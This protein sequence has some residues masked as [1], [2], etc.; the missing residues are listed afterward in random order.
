MNYI[1]K[2]DNNMVKYSV[3]Y[4]EEL[5]RTIK[6]EIIDKC[7]FRQHLS[8]DTVFL[9]NY[10]DY[11]SIYIR[12]FKKTDTKKLDNFGRKIYHVEYDEIERPML[13][14]AIDS[15][16]AKDSQKILEY[17]CGDDS[18]KKSDADNKIKELYERKIVLVYSIKKL[19]DTVITNDKEKFEELGMRIKEL[20]NI[21]DNI[22]LNKNLNLKNQ[23][24]YLDLLKESF[25][26]TKLD[27]IDYNTYQKVMNFNK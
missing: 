17:I 11:N 22:D 26:L 14:S 12:N 27:E 7:G 16:L 15:F 2:V 1:I 3:D 13:V 24:N 5:L 10:K 18:F 25:T 4:D 6:S 19:L 9:D 8:Y 23:V 21:M 20:E